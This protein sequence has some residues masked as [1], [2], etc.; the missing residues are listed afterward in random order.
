MTLLAVSLTFST[1]L[2]QT[3]S[4]ARSPITAELIR[5][6][7]AQPLETR[8][9]KPDRTLSADAHDYLQAQE[10]SEGTTKFWVFFTDKGPDVSQALMRPVAGA[11]TVRNSLSRRAKIGRD[12]VLFADLPVHESYVRE[13]MNLGAGLFRR[14]RWLNAG[15]FSGS[16]ATIKRIS[17]LPFVVE[18]R[19]ALTYKAP[20][21]PEPVGAGPDSPQ[22]GP[23]AGSPALD[24]GQSR[25]QITQIK[26]DIG[27]ALGFNG[28]GVTIAMLDTGYR[29]SHQAFA[30]AFVEGRVLA[31]YDFINNDANTAF[32]PGDP[33]SQWN[34]GTLTWSTCGG[35][36]AGSLFGPAFGANYLLAKTENVASETIQ[37]EFDWVA[38]M[39][40]ADSLG[41]DVISSSLAYSLWYDQSSYDGI[42]A[43]TSIAAGMAAELGIVVCNANGNAGPGAITLAAPADAFDILACGA[44]DADGALG[45][46]SSRGPTTDGRIKPELCARGVLTWCASAALDG[47]YTRASGTS[48][49]TPLVAGVTAQLISA[50]PTWS[51]FLI[52]KALKETASNAATPNNNLGWGIVNLEAALDWG[53]NFTANGQESIAVTELAQDV[54]FAD[55]S[56]LPASA[57]LWY[58]GDAQTSTLDT[59]AHAYTAT[60]LYDVG[61][62][63]QTGFGDLSR[64][65]ENSVAVIADTVI[66]RADSAFPGRTL[67]VAVDI[68][69][70]LSLAG[71]EIPLDY[72]ASIG[73]IYDSV[74]LGAR[75]VSFTQV[76]LSAIDPFNKRVVLSAST[77]GAPLAPGNGEALKVFF[78]LDSQAIPGETGTIDSGATGGKNLLFSNQSVSYPPRFSGTAFLAGT[79]KRGDANGD[80]RLNIADVTFLITRIF[81]SGKPPV[82]PAAGDVNGDGL[83]DVAD[84][85]FFIAYLFSGGPAPPP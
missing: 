65:R 32:E 50:R 82:T 5:K 78:T 10:T 79:P 15:A 21:R 14:S 35:Q 25:D 37:E 73:L 39:E 38:A 33:S 8:L 27:H 11:P 46:F 24:Y 9:I 84:V 61:L 74:A 51:P 80:G 6:R 45:G 1:G 28:S 2:G 30:A 49:S 83:N 71:F 63:I 34:H 54:S 13:I 57:W 75:T 41:A 85:T 26:S 52:M 60:G 3:T 59:V 29:K 4:A 47:S 18:I 36:F 76:G 43:V 42:T 53:A 70:G 16:M 12:Q 81:A 56:D 72:S 55:N 22:Q 77:S 23:L 62:T 66:L 31:E 69:N 17:T 48:L 20:L 40:W 58:F 7:Y 44:V 64:V 68:T 67:K 19:P